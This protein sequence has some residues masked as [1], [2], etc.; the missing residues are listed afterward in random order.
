MVLCSFAPML[1]FGGAVAGSGP[2]AALFAREG[3]S[4]ASPAFSPAAHHP[5]N[6][7]SMSA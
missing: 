3:A 5:G 4:A 2:R 6:V 7:A 1:K